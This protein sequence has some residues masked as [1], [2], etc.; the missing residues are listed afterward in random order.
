METN[1]L[2][3]ILF[4]FFYFSSNEEDWLAL[5]EKFPVLDQTVKWQKKRSESLECL[6]EDVTWKI[7]DKKLNRF[8]PCCRYNQF[9]KKPKT[10]FVRNSSI[11]NRNNEHRINW[12]LIDLVSLSA[13]HTHMDWSSFLIDAIDLIEIF[14]YNNSMRCIFHLS[15]VLII[16]STSQRIVN[17]HL[18]LSIV[19]LVLRMI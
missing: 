13:I 8:L 5:K 18:W 9:L 15:F 4:S 3:N 11:L 2:V 7:T 16:M 12:T 14:L 1:T 19:I 6:F 10:N 17:S